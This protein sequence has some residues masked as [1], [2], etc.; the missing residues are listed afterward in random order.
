MGGKLYKL[1]QNGLSW[2]IVPTLEQ[3]TGIGT[4]DN[5][6]FVAAWNPDPKIWISTDGDS[7]QETVS[8]N[9]PPA[10]IGEIVSLDSK[11]YVGVGGNGIY[12]SSDNG[13]IFEEFNQ[14]LIS[15]ATREV[16]VNP[17]DENEIYVGTW[18]RQG[19]Y[20]SK[21]RGKGYKRIATDFDVFTLRPDP[22][23]FS[24]VYLG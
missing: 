24:R 15:I 20:W 23:D 14:G 17:K 19:F 10:W 11:I 13:N 9:L 2:E 22:H 16:Y 18:D 5:T 21:N 7:F 8:E 3:V 6:L 12:V 4:D 1:A